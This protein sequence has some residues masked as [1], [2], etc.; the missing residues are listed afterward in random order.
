MKSGSCLALVSQPH[1]R[2]LPSASRGTAAFCA[3][4]VWLLGLFVASAPLHGALHQD[5][6]HAGHTCA[7]TLFREGIEDAVGSA[8]IIVTPALSPRGAT[9]A[10]TAVLVAD[11][12]VRLPPGCGPPLC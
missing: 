4:T 6:G 11:A 2:K 7:I 10:L 1:P 9:A 5:A 3:L 8:A 12:D